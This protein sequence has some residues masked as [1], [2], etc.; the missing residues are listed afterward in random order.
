MT[1]Q[2]FDVILLLGRPASGKSEIMDF[3]KKQSIV[4]RTENLHVG[5]IHEIDDFPMLWT[6]FEE[7]HILQNIL[8]KDRIQTDK[9]GYFL[10]E[11]QWHLLIERMNLEYQKFL[12]DKATTA[13][14]FTVLIEFSRGKEHGGYKAAFPHLAPEMLNRAA[15]LYVDVTYEESF[16]KNNRRFNPDKPDSI[17]EHG[18]PAD[19]MEK[20]YKEIDWEEVI[21][22]CSEY[23]PINGVQ[24]PFVVFPNMPE[25]TNDPEKLGPALQ[26]YLDQLWDLY[27]K[28]P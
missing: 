17:L 13:D 14:D 28:R 7:D 12:R 25:K 16:R 11:Y 22:G 10:H 20:L 18:L 24:V 3:L 23:L 4:K 21:E 8:G 26:L 6:W 5:E 15:I 27:K 19:K 1:K 9:H 2:H